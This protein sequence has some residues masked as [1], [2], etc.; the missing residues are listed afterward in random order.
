[1]LVWT[2][3]VGVCGTDFEIVSGQYGW[4]PPGQERL[5][6]GHESLGRVEE[7]SRYLKVAQRVWAKAATKD[8]ES[9][10]N[11]MARRATKV[12]TPSIAAAED[13]RAGK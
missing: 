12:R 4:A 7:A 11:D 1:M 5:I 8:F 2:L 3:A 9:L 6:I 13:E 10:K